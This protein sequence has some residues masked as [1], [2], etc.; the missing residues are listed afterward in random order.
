MNMS[1]KKTSE[2]KMS[3]RKYIAAAGAAVVVVAA[4]GAAYYLTT[5]SLE[6]QLQL[7]HRQDHQHL[8][9]HPNPQ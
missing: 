8:R 6:P 4:G 9:D 5:P 7:D 1:E 2:T 3:R